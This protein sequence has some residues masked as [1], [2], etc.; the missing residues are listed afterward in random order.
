MSWNTYKIQ[1]LMDLPAHR[2]PNLSLDDL[3][4][5]GPVA[6][7]H[8]NFRGALHFPLEEFAEPIMRAPVRVPAMP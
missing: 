1:E 5:A 2:R 7:R 6:T 4:A 3:A 8:I